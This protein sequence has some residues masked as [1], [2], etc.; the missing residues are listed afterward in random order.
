MPLETIIENSYDEDLGASA[1]FVAPPHANRRVSVKFGPT[2][3][4]PDTAAG[5]ITYNAESIDQLCGMKLDKATEELKAE[6][7]DIVDVK[8]T[9]FDTEIQS[10]EKNGT[11]DCPPTDGAPLNSTFDFIG[12]A[13]RDSNA[14][15]EKRQTCNLNV[16]FEENQPKNNIIEPKVIANSTF[17]LAPDPNA[18]FEKQKEKDINSTFNRVCNDVVD[19]DHIAAVTRLDTTFD[20]NKPK[21][22]STFNQGNK[23]NSTFDQPPEHSPTSTPCASPIASALNGSYRRHVNSTM[24]GRDLNESLTSSPCRYLNRSL[25]LPCR[26]PPGE[27]VVKKM[28][29]DLCQNISYS[30]INIMDAEAPALDHILK[31][32][33]RELAQLKAKDDS[34][35]NQARICTSIILYFFMFVILL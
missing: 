29:S 16:T 11:F 5:D 35:I 15:F 6:T 24:H 23:C 31:L 26:P 12:N 9:T 1:T 27:E 19:Q 22:N 10:I 3:V 20:Q 30:C 18:T 13:K 32:E 28:V 17:D 25:S 7:I 21:L 4:I 8:N 14:T 34:F 33:P 2:S